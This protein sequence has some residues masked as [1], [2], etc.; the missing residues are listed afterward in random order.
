MS[1]E[2]KFRVWNKIR[3]IF[4]VQGMNII[5]FQEDAAMSLELPYMMSEEGTVIQQ[6]TGLQDKNGKEIYEGDILK[7]NNGKNN[8]S[9]VIYKLSSF[10]VCGINFGANWWLEEYNDSYEV[11]GNILEN[12]Q[13]SV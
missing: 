3:N 8:L 2:I 9:E 12:K 11:V 13:D 4:I 10:Y 5:E 1:R 6:F 7:F